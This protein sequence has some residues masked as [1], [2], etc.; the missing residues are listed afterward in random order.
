MKMGYD[1]LALGVT[2]LYKILLIFNPD[3]KPFV[4]T[5]SWVPSKVK[6]AVKISL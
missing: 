1:I 4:Y 2:C 3:L 5:F 6:E